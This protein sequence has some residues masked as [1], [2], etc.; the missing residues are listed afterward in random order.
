M[1]IQ[2]TKCVMVIDETLPLGMI[3][4]TAAVLGATLGKRF[5][6]AIGPDVFDKDEN[7]HLGI[8]AIPIPTLKGNPQMLRDLRE[9]LF[10]PEFERL[11]VVDFSDI[12]QGCNAYD[13]YIDNMAG[14]AEADLRYFGL[15]IY[16][17]K[18]RVNRLT[19]SMPL[20]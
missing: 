12:A 4:N 17:D 15:A 16:G 11:A 20:L 9:K 2:K 10:R 1:D 7:R 3:A 14:A 6:E 8:V 19:G 5:P 13:A 18:K